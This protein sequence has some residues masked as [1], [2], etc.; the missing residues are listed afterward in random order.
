MAKLEVGLVVMVAGERGRILQVGAEGIEVQLKLVAW[1]P[2]AL[3][4]GGLRYDPPERVEYGPDWRQGKVISQTDEAACIM[5]TEWGTAVERVPLW[6]IRPTIKRWTAVSH[7]P[8]AGAKSDSDTTEVVKVLE[9]RTYREA[10]ESWARRWYCPVIFNG[11]L[12]S[13]MQQ[14]ESWDSYQ[15]RVARYEEERKALLRTG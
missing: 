9:G 10:V 7:V 12:S 2:D 8:Q 11:D 5:D 6:E 13:E 14:G 3:V 15:D 4:M 1:L